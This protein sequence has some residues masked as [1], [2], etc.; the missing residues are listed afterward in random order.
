MQSNNSGVM[1]PEDKMDSENSQV[2]IEMSK[3]RNLDV[4]YDV[5]FCLD[6]G[7]TIHVNSLILQARSE[8]FRGMLS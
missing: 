3:F 1:S 2:L 5:V 6:D 8:Y 7:N 4:F